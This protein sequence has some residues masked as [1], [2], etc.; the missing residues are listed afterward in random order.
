MDWLTQLLGSLMGQPAGMAPMAGAM[1]PAAM[2]PLGASLAEGGV[3]LPQPRPPID[4]GMAANAEGL[5]ENKKDNSLLA[6]LRGVKVPP[7]PAQQ[8]VSTPGLPAI[9]PIQGGGLAELLA[10]LGVGPAQVVKGASLPGTLG[11]ALGGR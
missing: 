6:S 3:P 7:A 2:P 1:D 10:S 5:V 4:A 11:Q 8:K 9:R